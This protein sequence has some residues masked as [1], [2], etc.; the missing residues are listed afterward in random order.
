[1]L[2]PVVLGS[3]VLLVLN[4]HVLKARWPSWWTGKLSDVAGLIF[5]PWVLVSL[6]EVAR[7]IPRASP[8]VVRTCAVLTALVFSAI[9]VSTAASEVWQWTLG[10]LQWPLV[11]G[12][13]ELLREAPRGLHPVAH[14]ADL[15]DL[16]ALPALVLAVWLGERRTPGCA[17]LRSRPGEAREQGQAAGA[18]CPSP[19]PRRQHCGRTRGTQ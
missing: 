3:V 19:Q 16:L 2:H 1:M 7:S 9:Q 12:W 11:N 8:G 15:G 14:V 13:R 5:F 17:G 6:W 10:A 18:A 4:D